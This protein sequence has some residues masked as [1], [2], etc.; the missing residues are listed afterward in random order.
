MVLGVTV[1]NFALWSDSLLMAAMLY[2]G[3]NTFQRIT[4][5]PHRDKLPFVFQV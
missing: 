5:D 1:G 2:Y 3:G 4:Q